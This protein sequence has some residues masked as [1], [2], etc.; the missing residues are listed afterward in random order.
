MFNTEKENHTE[1]QTQTHRLIEIDKTED[2][3][4]DRMT[5]LVTHTMQSLSHTLIHLP[6]L[7]PRD[8]HTHTYSKRQN[9]LGFGENI[10]FWATS[11]QNQ[12]WIIY[13]LPK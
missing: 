12:C 4:T 5:H 6:T 7:T 13:F 1:N 11:S 10:V 3:T 8:T 2:K 9:I